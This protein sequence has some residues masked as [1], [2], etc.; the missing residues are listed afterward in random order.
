MAI[1]ISEFGDFKVEHRK[2]TMLK[3]ADDLSRLPA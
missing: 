1:K 2:G 3:D